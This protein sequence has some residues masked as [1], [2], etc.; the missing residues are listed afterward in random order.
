[1]HLCPVVWTRTPTWP[2]N[3]TIASPLS[4]AA[5]NVDASFKVW[6]VEFDRGRLVDAFNVW[7][8]AGLLV[9]TG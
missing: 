8:E 6:P 1:M 4:P 7:H 9:T 2:L 5:V 3:S